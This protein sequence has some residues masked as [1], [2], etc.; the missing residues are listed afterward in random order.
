MYASK[1]EE[2]LNDLG[3]ISEGLVVECLSFVNQHKN[4]KEFH[5]Q[6]TLLNLFPTNSNTW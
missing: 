4:T 6:M 5:P 1:T 3:A 2:K